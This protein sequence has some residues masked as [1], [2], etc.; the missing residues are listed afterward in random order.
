MSVQLGSLCLSMAFVCCSSARVGRYLWRYLWRSRQ[1]DLSS[2]PQSVLGPGTGLRLQNSSEPKI[3]PLHTSQTLH[4]IDALCPQTGIC[5]LVSKRVCRICF[6]FLLRKV[7]FVSQKNTPFCSMHYRMYETSE[8]NPVNS[9]CNLYCWSRS[10]ATPRCNKYYVKLLQNKSQ[11]IIN[12][13]I[14]RP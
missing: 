10:F 12:G 2:I 7:P 3:I 4:N 9:G 13:S 5:R 8:P 11:T 6:S 14:G 1:L